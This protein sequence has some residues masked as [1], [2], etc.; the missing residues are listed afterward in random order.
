MFAF[1][2]VVTEESWRRSASQ[3]EERTEAQRITC[4]RWGTGSRSR[5][6]PLSDYGQLASRSLSIPEDSIAVDPQKED[7]ADGDHQPVMA[8]TDPS[9]Q[10]PAV[11]CP[12]GGRRRRPISVI[13]GVSLYGNSQPEDIENLLTQVRSGVHPP[14]AAG[15]SSGFLAFVVPLQTKQDV[16]FLSSLCLQD[17]VAAPHLSS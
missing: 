3:D 5:P 7:I 1:E 2:K 16:A 11:G 8:S 17:G 6:R 9:N 12:R 13:G 4:R 14:K 15:P 10:N